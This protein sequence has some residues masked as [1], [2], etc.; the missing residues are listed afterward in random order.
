MFGRRKP[1]FAVEID[2]SEFDNESNEINVDRQ[3][4]ELNEK[5][6][7]LDLLNEGEEEEFIYPDE[8]EDVEDPRPKYIL[9]AE[10]VRERT[11][12]AKLTGKKSLLEDDENI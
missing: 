4:A 3:E 10:F 6:D 2:K 1:G 9:L 12:G 5:I 8:L 11:K 7:L